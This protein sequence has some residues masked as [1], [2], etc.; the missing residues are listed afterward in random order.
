[1]EARYIL[2]YITVPTR[3][4]GEDIARMLVSGK[5]A[6]CVNIVPGLTS[7]YNWRGNVEMDSE[8]L[9]II[10]TRNALFEELSTAVKQIHPYDV[11][12]IIGIPII[13]GSNAYLD[14]IDSETSL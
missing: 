10:K 5:M 7:I 14:W 1:M 13:A 12:E 4:V 2:I 11:P 6:A 8:L 9:L 3:E